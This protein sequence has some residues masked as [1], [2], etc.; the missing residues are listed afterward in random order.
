MM[1][2]IV[3]TEKEE[4]GEFSQLYKKDS[5]SQSYFVFTIIYRMVLGLSMSHFN[6]VEESTIVNVFYAIIFL[7]FLMASIPYAKAYHNYRAII[8]QLTNLIILSVTMYYRSMKSNTDPS[9]TYQIQSPA[10]LEVV[11]IFASLGI[12]AGCL[13]Y[14]LIMRLKECLKKPEDK[15]AQAE[16]SNHLRTEDDLAERARNEIVIAEDYVPEGCGL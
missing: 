2:A 3:F 5:T 8:V 12:S 16:R 6:E 15:I 10:M 14:E 11:S 4:F 13:F 7:V 1:G 9:V